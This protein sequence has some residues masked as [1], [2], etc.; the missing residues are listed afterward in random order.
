M[1][2]QY[3]VRGDGDPML[4]AL[5]EAFY[6]VWTVLAAHDPYRDR[7]QDHDRKIELSRTLMVFVANGVTD[8]A[9]LRRSGVKEHVS[10]AQS[11]SF[12]NFRRPTSGLTR[13]RGNSLSMSLCT[14]GTIRCVCEKA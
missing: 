3:P 2:S 6:D 10:N 11:L 13:P 5:E 4:L 12:D 14:P 1:A 7:T 8:V 9:E